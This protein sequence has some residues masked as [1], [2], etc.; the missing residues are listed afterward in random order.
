MPRGK[1]EKTPVL[2]KDPPRKVNLSD[3]NSLK[4]ALDECAREV[5]LLRGL[6]VQALSHTHAYTCKQIRT[7]TSTRA[8]THTHTHT[9]THKHTHTHTYTHTHTHTHK[10]T[11]THRSTSYK[12]NH[13]SG[14]CA[15]AIST[16]GSGRWWTWHHTFILLIAL[17]KAIGLNI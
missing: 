16:R 7:L 9:H 4:T 17:E 14:A 13:L 15:H 3:G 6:C 10:H 8:H 12:H 2:S 11:N 1:E 5:R